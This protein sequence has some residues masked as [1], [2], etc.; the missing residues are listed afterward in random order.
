MAGCLITVKEHPIRGKD[1]QGNRHVCGLL[2]IMLGVCT[3]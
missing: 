3:W 2:N 1:V